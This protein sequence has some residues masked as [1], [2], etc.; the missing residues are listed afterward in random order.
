MLPRSLL[1]LFA[2]ASLASAALAEP[3]PHVSIPSFAALPTPLPLP[4][5]ST[6]NADQ[7]VATAKA[8][9]LASHRLLLIDLGAN[10][11]P[12][13]RILAGTMELPELRAFIARHYV[14]AVV[15]VGRFDRNGQI[16][17]HYGLKGRLEGVPSVLIV[18]PRNDRLIDGGRTAALSNARAMT[19]QALAD[20]LAQWTPPR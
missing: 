6:A 15:D 13:C 20:W 12:D 18:D 1:A 10:W 11:C 17:A 9:A 2:A 7:T 3:A 5:D 14:V 8:T 4:Y 19:P 16:A